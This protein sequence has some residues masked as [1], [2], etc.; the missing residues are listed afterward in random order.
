MLAV[1]MRPTNRLA[2]FSAGTLEDFMLTIGDDPYEIDQTRLKFQ[3]PR[4]LDCCSAVDAS[5][6]QPPWFST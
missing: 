1:P 2:K 4:A 5:S 6:F 3:L